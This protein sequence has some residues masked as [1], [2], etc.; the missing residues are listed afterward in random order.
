M[1]PVLSIAALVLATVFTSGLAWA[2]W[3]SDAWSAESVRRHGSPAITIRRGSIQVVLPAAA[4]NQ[5]YDEGV[6]TERA[7]SDFVE[8]YAQRCSGLVDL[9]VP[10]ADLK[11]SLS[12]Q[13][14]TSLDEISED[15]EVLTALKTEYLKRGDAIGSPMLFTASPGRFNFTLDYVPKRQVRCAAPEMPSS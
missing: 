4:L 7:L 10:Q 12:L 1:K 13:T 15:D 2:D 11:V 6:T 3:L 8:R 9:N 5:A 14:R